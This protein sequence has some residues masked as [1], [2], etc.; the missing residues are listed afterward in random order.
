MS[1]DPVIANAA[2]YIQLYSDGNCRASNEFQIEV[3][4]AAC[5]WKDAKAARDW[6]FKAQAFKFSTAAGLQEFDLRVKIDQ[7][8]SERTANAAAA[9][10]ADQKAVSEAVAARAAEA[11]LDSKI[12]AEIARAGVAEASL[13]AVDV[14]A[15]AFDLAARN[16][17]DTAYK[18]ADT[19]LTNALAAEESARIAAC[20]ANQQA[21]ANVVGASP[22]TLDSLNDL[23]VHYTSMDAGQ[24]SLI[25]S[26]ITA[27]NELRAEVDVLT[28]QA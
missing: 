26:L 2:S 18:S 28:N 21:I 27:V 5:I 7:G 8:D 20:L 14:A 17:L 11:G 6:K 9:A 1:G 3:K 13:T 12:D 4:D 19:V 15:A 16:V 10:A 23:V 24:E 22:E 25:Q